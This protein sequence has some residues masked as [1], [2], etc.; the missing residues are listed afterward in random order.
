MVGEHEV[1]KTW[2]FLHHAILGKGILLGIF[3]L[4]LPNF[5]MEPENQPLEKEIAIGFTII[6]RFQ[7]LN[8]GGVPMAKSQQRPSMGPG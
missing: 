4:T 7:P 3:H 6:F 2:R 5:N 1:E 8:F